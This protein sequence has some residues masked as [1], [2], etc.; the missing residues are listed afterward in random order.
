MNVENYG[1]SVN[2]ITYWNTYNSNLKILRY[3]RTLVPNVFLKNMF[4]SIYRK[5]KISSASKSY[6]PSLKKINSANNN[7]S[8]INNNGIGF[9]SGGVGLNVGY[10]SVKASSDASSTASRFY[11]NGADT[12][13]SLSDHIYSE[14]HNNIANKVAPAQNG[15]IPMNGFDP[16]FGMQNKSQSTSQVPPPINQRISCCYICLFALNYSSRP[17]IHT[18]KKLA[19]GMG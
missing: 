11:D 17:Y 16:N 13:S 15:K 2:G 4:I 10:G 7:I 19:L 9:G 5:R 3:L 18:P 14:N 1:Y 6:E 8:N 12:T